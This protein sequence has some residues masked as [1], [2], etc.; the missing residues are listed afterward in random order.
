MKTRIVVLKSE[1]GLHARPAAILVKK[2]G[3]FKSK[4]DVEYQGHS[5]SAKSVM[6]LMSL[7]LSKGA[8]LTLKADGE[9][10]DAAL[11]SLASLVENNFA[12]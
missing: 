10:A 8:E 7:G 6:G 1:D 4:I 12:I 3:E 5:K 2:A 11:E 9:D